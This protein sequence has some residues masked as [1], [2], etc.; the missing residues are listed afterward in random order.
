M[1]PLLCFN[2]ANADA[3]AA[4]KSVGAETSQHGALGV[5]CGWEAPRLAAASAAPA[6]PGY[7]SRSA[8]E[9]LDSKAVLKAKVKILAG[10]MKASKAT[11]VY[12]GA[13]IS[14][15]AGMPDY[16]SKAHGSVAPHRGAAGA[17][18]VSRNRLDF[19]PTFGHHAVAG[20]EEKGY[21]HHWLQQNH[22]R[23]AQKAGF[24]QPKLNEIHGAWG[25]DKNQ[26]MMMDDTLRGDLLE[27]AMQWAGKV[28][29]CLA[30]GT[31][32]CGMTSDT[33]AEQAAGAGGLVIVNLQATALDDSAALR[34]WGPIDEV[35]ALLAKELKVKVPNKKAE[36]RGDAWTANHPRCKFSTKKRKPADPL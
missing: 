5:G 14:T 3:A 30:M 11:V 1:F 31:S 27:W 4:K 29:L 19:A 21:V 33:V 24:P 32:L 12:T 23:L 22:D 8:S 10:L 16:A 13:G 9:Y 18:A 20:F 26:V 36:A 7:N 15:A 34:I 17:A 6:R 35:L 25:D 28:Q 2:P